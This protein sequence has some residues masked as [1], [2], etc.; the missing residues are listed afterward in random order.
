MKKRLGV[1]LLLGSLVAFGLAIPNLY[2]QSQQVQPAKQTTTF[3]QRLFGKTPVETAKPGFEAKPAELKPMEIKSGEFSSLGTSYFISPEATT[4]AATYPPLSLV[5]SPSLPAAQQEKVNTWLKDNAKQGVVLSNPDEVF[6]KNTNIS[7]YKNA[8]NALWIGSFDWPEGTTIPN[9]QFWGLSKALAEELS[10]PPTV[11]NVKGKAFLT[12]NTEVRDMD[13]NLYDKLV[14][15]DN[16]KVKRSNFFAKTNIG[17][18]VMIGNENTTTLSDSTMNCEG[19]YDPDNLTGSGWSTGIYI[20]TTQFATAPNINIGSMSYGSDPSHGE[21]SNNEIHH[22]NVGIFVS[23]GA[24]VTADNNNIHH[25]T[26]GTLFYAD[27]GTTSCVGDRTPPLGEMAN[28]TF[29]SSKIGVFVQAGRP[30][31]STGNTFDTGEGMQ[32]GLVNQSGQT[33]GSVENALNAA[34]NHWRMTGV[35]GGSVTAGTLNATYDAFTPRFTFETLINYRLNPKYIANIGPHGAIE[36]GRMPRTS[37]GGC[38]L[39]R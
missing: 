33:V 1:L 37:V 25:T 2:S 21:L 7:S 23:P 34:A 38:S 28:N 13:F 10:L 27:C 11:I 12:K 31:I 35:T 22:C 5:I 4:M 26:I 39:V 24:R 20:S 3:W 32:I 14:I 6:K 15:A 16:S 19:T 9:G 8:N 30:V 18:I 17:A 36:A 29:S